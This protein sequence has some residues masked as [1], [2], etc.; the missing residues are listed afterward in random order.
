MSTSDIKPASAPVRMDLAIP[1]SD[2]VQIRDVRL[3]QCNSRVESSAFAAPHPPRFQ[4]SYKHEA[5]TQAAPDCTQIAVVA[6]FHFSA[7]REGEK[8]GAPCIDIDASFLVTYVA[9]G[10][11]GVGPENFNSFGA[12]NGVFNAWPYWREL[13][14]SLISRMGLPAF[15]LPVMRLGSTKPLP[16]G[17][18]DTKVASEKRASCP[19]RRSD[20]TF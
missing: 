16:E 18:Q 3:I 8:P 4:A 1:V 6:R 20:A 9:E 14:H 11:T 5:S 2:R 19:P 7:I 12:L 17:P 15:V 13:L 10:L